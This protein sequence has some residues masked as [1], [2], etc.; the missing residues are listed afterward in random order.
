MDATTGVTA[1]Q[2]TL[3]ALKSVPTWLL[4]GVCIFVLSIWLWPS[5]FASLPEP[6][7]PALPTAL[8]VAGILT[9]CKIASLGFTHLLER[10]R[11]SLAQDR[12]RLVDLYRPLASLF[13]TRH[14]TVCTGSAA[15]YLRHRLENAREELGACRRRTV[16]LKR[17]WR[18]L[19]DRQVSSSAEI[20]FSGEFPLSQII[21]LVKKKARHVAPDLFRLVNRADRSRYEEP[22]RGLM[23]D[24]EFAL[25]EHIDREHR[26]LS[27]RVG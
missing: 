25:F 7:R 26:R 14:V 22:D 3:D 9:S 4:I 10:R 15:P 21:D 24:A 23:T 27:K 8:L 13:L 18:A 11:R 16:G 12:E 6:L 17:A 20:E 5:L 19:L 1:T 2:K